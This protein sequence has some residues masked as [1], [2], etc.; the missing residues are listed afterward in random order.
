MG[1]AKT[2]WKCWTAF[3]RSFGDSSPVF[4][5]LSPSEL[6][7]CLWLVFLSL[8]GL[9][10]STIRVYL[11][12]LS[13]QVKRLGGPGFLI[14]RGSWFIH[15]TLKAIKK[16][17][18]PAKSVF[19]RPITVPVL[20]EL[21]KSV[22]LSEG[23]NLLFCA[24]VALGVFGCCRINEI[25]SSVKRGVKLFIRNK[26]VIFKPDFVE[27]TLWN[28]KTSPMIKKFIARIPSGSVN[29]W[30]LLHSYRCT[31]A[32]FGSPTSPFFITASGKQVSRTEL[33]C[34]IRQSLRKIFP[35]IPE[36]EWN[37]ASLRKGGASS[38]VNAGV[39]S[40]VIEKLGNWKTSE[41]KK[42]IHCSVDDILEAQ[43]SSARTCV[44]SQLSL[45]YPDTYY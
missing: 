22:D 2:V 39:H 16:G 42:Y 5:S 21:I 38:A 13:A 32:G 29:P 34:F 14:P 28:T 44:N 35:N 41:F 24:M 17:C 33:I 11:Y 36:H 37:G 9:S 31:K 7:V 25:C 40:E 4:H 12:S 43:K 15:S 1:R 19:R 18:P 27:V 45:S 26:D 30:R 8:K 20:A 3:L 10:P 23:D 6:V